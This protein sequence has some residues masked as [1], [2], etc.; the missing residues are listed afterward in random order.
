MGPKPNS[1]YAVLMSSVLILFLISSC[2]YDSEEYLYPQISNTCDTSNYTYTGA[3]KPL[4]QNSCYSCH[5]NSTSGSGNGIKL[6]NYTDV[7]LKADDGSLLGSISHS[8]GYSAMPLNAPKLED[9]KI[10]VVQKWID[11]GAPNN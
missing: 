10:V 3:V 1:F 8:Q 5:S 7:K 4:L 9:C 2:Y 11:S 6:E